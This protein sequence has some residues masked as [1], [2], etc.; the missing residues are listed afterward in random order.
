MLQQEQCRNEFRAFLNRWVEESDLEDEQILEA[1][2]D[3]VNTWMN[4][5]VMTFES[6]MP[7]DEE[8]E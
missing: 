4:E 6:D 7:M 8:D 3:G 1:V 2:K 5:D